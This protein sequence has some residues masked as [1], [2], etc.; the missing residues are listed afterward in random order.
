[1][2]KHQKVQ[3]WEKYDGGESAG[4]KC[5]RCGSFL[6]EHEDR[7]SCGKCGYTKHS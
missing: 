4:E 3:I 2:A 6:A 1:M 5:P 7:K